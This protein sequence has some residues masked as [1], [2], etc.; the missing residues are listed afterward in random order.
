MTRAL[1]R[2]VDAGPTYGTTD[3]VEIAQR[4]E[5]LEAS[6]L[7]EIPSRPSI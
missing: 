4:Q 5:T 6:R 1:L 3:T 7:P 2:E